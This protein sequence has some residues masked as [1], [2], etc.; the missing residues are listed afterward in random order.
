MKLKKWKSFNET[1]DQERKVE[2]RSCD[3]SQEKNNEIVKTEDM[4]VLF[5][6]CG[7]TNAG[8]RRWRR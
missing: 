7:G 6:I 1:R 3:D 2:R 8:G 4:A 5:R